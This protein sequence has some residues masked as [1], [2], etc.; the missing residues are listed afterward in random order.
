MAQPEFFNPKTWPIKWRRAFL[1]TLPI[2]GTVWMACV[3]L[4][5]VLMMAIAIPML[6]F[7]C[8]KESL[9]DKQPSDQTE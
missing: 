6:P 9:W 8:L 1:L 7:M 3:I 4:V 2:S 5:G